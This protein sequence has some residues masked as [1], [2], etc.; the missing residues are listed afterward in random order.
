MRYL[1]REEHRSPQGLT[2]LVIPAEMK[3]CLFFKDIQPKGE[4]ITKLFRVDCPS[5][6]IF[7]L[8]VFLLLLGKTTE[9]ERW[10]RNDDLLLVLL[11]ECFIWKDEKEMKPHSASVFIE[12]F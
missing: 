9:E 6:A 2:I 11:Y 1:I 12:Y 4:K 7:L 3:S 8:K 5:T 10:R